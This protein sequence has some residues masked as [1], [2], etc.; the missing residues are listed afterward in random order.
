MVIEMEAK[1]L[2]SLFEQ[3]IGN[4]KVM[5]NFQTDGKVVNIQVLDDYTVCTN[6]ECTCLDGDTNKVDI[7][8]W[9]MKFI[10]VLNHKE[11]IKFT[12]TDAALFIEQSTF[13]CTLLREYEARRELPDTSNFELKPAMSGRLK[14]LVHCCQAGT[15]LAKEMAKSMPDPMFVND[16]YYVDFMQTFFIDSIKYPTHCIPFSTLR[17]FVYKLGENAQYCDLPEYNTIYFKSGNYEFWV[18]TTDYNISGN[19]IAAIEKKLADCKPITKVKFIEYKDRLT[20]LTSAFPKTKLI[21]AIGNGGFN[22]GVDSNNAHMLVGYQLPKTILS[23]N[24]TS[25][26][27]DYIVK[28]FGESEEVEVLRGA[29]CLCLK[30]GTKTLLISAVL[31]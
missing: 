20:V 7:S 24:V 9:L 10:G 19:I 28:I 21:F 5:F 12:I 1:Y 2:T 15:G 6:V 26:Q 13:Y 18:P 25:A 30:S 3:F 31:Y 8:V 29:N 17:S 4:N 27:L 22:V 14:Y 11:P 23:L 16:K